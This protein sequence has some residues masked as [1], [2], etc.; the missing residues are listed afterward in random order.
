MF[1]ALQLILLLR[2]TWLPELALI[3][4][5]GGRPIPAGHNLHA[6]GKEQKVQREMGREAIGRDGSSENLSGHPFIMA[7]AVHIPWW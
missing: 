5:G 4:Y 1:T 3:G 7:H 2:L 6:S